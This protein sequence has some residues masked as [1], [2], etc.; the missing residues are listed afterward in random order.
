MIAHELG[1]EVI[2][3]VVIVESVDEVVRGGGGV[4]AQEEMSDP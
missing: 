1:C 4:V 2:G 3:E